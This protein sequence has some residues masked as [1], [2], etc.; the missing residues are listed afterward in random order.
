[1]EEK[2]LLQLKQDDL[3]RIRE[4]LYIAQD[5][6]CAILK[7]EFPIEKMVVDHKHKAWYEAVGENNAGLV[8]GCLHFQVN[9][10]EGKVLNTY[11]R[12]GM[13]ALG[14][15]LPELLRSL[16]DYLEKEPLNLIHPNEKPKPKRLGKRLF[17][18]INKAY[19]QKYP[20]RK[21]LEYPK[22]KPN[23]LPILTERWLKL[24]EEL[25]IE[26]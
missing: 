3:K 7:K 5:K 22:H 9:A 6:K 4:E 2:E 23:K 10:W 21:A 26:S 12:L 24:M 13:A 11:K 8:R 1:M 20:K 18:Q 19:K 14:M 17:A 16:A 15:P 25:G